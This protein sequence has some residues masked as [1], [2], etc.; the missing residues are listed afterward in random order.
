[1]DEVVKPI[2]TSRAQVRPN[3]VEM[4]RRTTAV[5]EAHQEESEVE[6]L[7]KDMSG[8]KQGALLWLTDNLESTKDKMKS[9]DTQ[10]ESHSK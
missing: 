6:E 9:S 7:W 2:N 4:A 5:L 1:M 8:Q 10:D 3:I